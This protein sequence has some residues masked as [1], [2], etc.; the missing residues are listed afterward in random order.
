MF[1]TFVYELGGKPAPPENIYQR[2]QPVA[3]PRAPQAATPVPAAPLL[4][5][6][7]TEGQKHFIEWCRGAD[8]F[9]RLDSY[10]IPIKETQE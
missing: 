7:L 3:E 2:N 1:K 10:R 8:L 5:T 4:P 9:D 6:P